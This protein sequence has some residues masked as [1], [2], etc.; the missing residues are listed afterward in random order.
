MS[1]DTTDLEDKIASRI[2]PTTAGALVVS[3]E[4]GGV[5]F[6]SMNDVMEFAKMM[7]VARAGVRKHLRNDPGACLA[8]CVQALEWRMSPFAVANKTYFVNDQIAYEA[9]LIHAIILRRAPIKGRVKHAYSGEGTTRKLKVW[10]ELRDEPGEIVEYETPPIGKIHPQNSPLWKN[11]P[12]QQLHYY[13]TRAWCRRH[14]PDVILGIYADDELRDNPS[15]GDDPAAI[16]DITPR[17][18]QIESPAAKPAGKFAAFAQQVKETSTAAAPSVSEREPGEDGGG[19][20]TGEV[21]DA[22]GNGPGDNSQTDAGEVVVDDNGSSASMPS[23][24]VEDPVAE[25]RAA[26]AAAKKAGDKRVVPR[27]YREEGRDEEYDAWVS[28]YDEAEK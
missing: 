2:N 18:D 27:R 10:A 8:V 20:E 19:G 1:M 13:A 6:S 15:L 4:G 9:Q 17:E 7:S 23:D 16:R 25:A 14:F 12:D 26:G 22:S 28:G 3:Q 24:P 11:D 21:A 5:T